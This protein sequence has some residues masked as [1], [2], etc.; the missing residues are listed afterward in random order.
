MTVQLWCLLIGAMLPYVWH[1][2]SVPFKNKQFGEVDIGEPRAQGMGLVD[3]GARV[4]A[5]QLN[6]W[7]ALG[8]FSVANLAA[9]MA[10]VDPEGYWS[11]AAIIWVVARV[12]HGGFYIAGFG[13]VRVLC[14][15][16]G[17]GMCLWIFSM[18]L[19]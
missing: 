8:L 16:V 6:A 1:F 9:F 3:T 14:F 15:A 12:C 13:L 18:A 17:L 5:A 7:E 4:W 19:I 11:L 2:V 10:G